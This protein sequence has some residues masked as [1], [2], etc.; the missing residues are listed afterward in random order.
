MNL[1]EQVAVAVEE[2][3]VD[4]RAAGDRRDDVGAVLRGLVEGS[5]DTS[6]TQRVNTAAS[7]W[8]N[9]SAGFERGLPLRAHGCFPKEVGEKRAGK[10]VAG[11][12]SRT[13]TGLGTWVARPRATP[14]L[15]LGVP[16]WVSVNQ[17]DPKAG[18][19]APRNHE[20]PFVP[21]R[22]EPRCDRYVVLV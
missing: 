4:A 17:W 15:A 18:R 22:D 6:S 20:T 12:P 14:G 9:P 7:E 1:G 11:V 2:G 8:G 21:Q 10:R 19:D 16:T 13:D 5:K 3:A